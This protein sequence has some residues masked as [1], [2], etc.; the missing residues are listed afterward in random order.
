MIL[1]TRRLPKPAIQLL[2]SHA[3]LCY[4]NSSRSLSRR[5]LLRKIRR[6]RGVVCLLTDRM[7]RQVIAA[8][9]HLKIIA[10]VAVGYD[11]IDVPY[12]RSRGII[13][14]NTPGV[15]T[16]AVA[17]LT[18]ALILAVARRVV[19]S[20]R[21]TRRG[22]FKGWDMELMLGT[23]LKGK[24]LGLIGF[25]RIGQ[26]V[27]QRAVGFGMSIQYYQR[28]PVEHSGRPVPLEDL[29][30]TSDFV[31]IHL[32]LTPETHHLL[33]RKRLA[34]LKRTAFLINTSRGPIVDEKALATALEH[35]RLA[36]AGLDV[37][38]REPR[39]EPSLKKMDRLVLLPH[40]GSATVETRTAMAVKACE[41]V[42]AFLRG[43]TP[44]NLVDGTGGGRGV[45]GLL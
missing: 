31:S 16:D 19:E 45:T 22:R 20:D 40:I 9:E 38:E 34:L 33:D 32:P 15:L 17:D 10:N 41:S 13:V 7:D 44:P 35:H 39:I 8:A 30:R 28:H 27:A 24:V 4:H 3:P 43:E 11:N 12:A 6:A 2:R 36:G 5:E 18:W 25:G 42:L 29:L 26:A 37:F 21:F 14:T 1:V 23:E